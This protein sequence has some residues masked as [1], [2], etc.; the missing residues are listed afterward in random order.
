MTDVARV[1]SL[2]VEDAPVH[3]MLERHEPQAWCGSR[4]QFRHR[5]RPGSANAV[6]CP[7]CLRALRRGRPYAR[8]SRR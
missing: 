4:A 5:V 1:W 7:K 8:A 2:P 3:A 6:T